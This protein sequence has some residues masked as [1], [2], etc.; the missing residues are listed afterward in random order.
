MA[1]EPELSLR[2]TANTELIIY[3]GL[4][5]G[6]II[7]LPV[8]NKNITITLTAAAAPLIGTTDVDMVSY[9]DSVI[10]HRCRR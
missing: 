4:G 1:A 2:D 5:S 3:L 6:N 7:Y 10:L 8:I 9:R